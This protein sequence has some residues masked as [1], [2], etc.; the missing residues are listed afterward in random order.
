[1]ALLLHVQAA[2]DGMNGQDFLEQPLA[3]S[4]CFSTGANRRT[5]RAR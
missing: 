3:V 4:W 5:R 1:M 2:I